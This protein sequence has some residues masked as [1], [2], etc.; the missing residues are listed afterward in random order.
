MSWY[1]DPDSLDRLAAHLSA[2]AAD[3]RDRARVVRASAAATHWQGAA[4]DSFHASVLH[5]SRLIDRAADELEDAAA[6]LHRHADTVRAEIARLLAVE[7]AA[8]HVVSAGVSSLAGLL[9]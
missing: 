1:G 9:R 4:A 3:V 2:S 7:R 5:E 6:G 8:E